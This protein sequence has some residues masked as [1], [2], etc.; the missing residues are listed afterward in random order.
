MGLGAN[1]GC[2]D[3]MGGCEHVI[4]GQTTLS[5]SLLKRCLSKGPGPAEGRRMHDT[6]QKEG[7]MRRWKDGGLAVKSNVGTT[8]NDQS[9]ETTLTRWRV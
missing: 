9:T 2:D 3:A 8:T 5:T 4:T 6:N 7:Q 1:C